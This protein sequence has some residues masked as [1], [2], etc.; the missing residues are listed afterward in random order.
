MFQSE[1]IFVCP[2]FSRWFYIPVLYTGHYIHPLLGRMSRNMPQC[3]DDASLTLCWKDTRF[4][5][6]LFNYL[7]FGLK[8]KSS[9][10]LIDSALMIWECQ[11][12]TTR[13]KFLKYSYIL[14]FLKIK[15][16]EIA[17]V[18]ILNKLYLAFYP[19]AFSIISELAYSLTY[20]CRLS[21][22]LLLE[23]SEKYTNY[24]ANTS[25]INLSWR[26]TV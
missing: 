11:P 4:M 13:V 7:I 10:W 23:D 16:T 18:H 20:N 8:L 12:I 19:H 24:T 25:H 21:Y 17:R 9:Q 22:K 6:M 15:C 2:Y 26:F 5:Q 3:V 14:M 1:C